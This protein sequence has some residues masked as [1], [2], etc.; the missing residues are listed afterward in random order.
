MNAAIAAG[1]YYAL[2]TLIH[3]SQY[4]GFK[5][6][7]RLTRVKLNINVALIQQLENSRLT[8]ASSAA[9]GGRI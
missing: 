7:E 8:P 6:P 4:L 5:I 9:S 3:V 1:H 2:H